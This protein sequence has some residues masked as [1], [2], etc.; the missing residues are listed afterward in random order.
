MIPFA[1]FARAAIFAALALA[2]L[3]ACAQEPGAPRQEAREEARRITVTGYGEAAAA[4]D[5]ARISAAVVAQGRT[6]QAAMAANAQAMSRVFD[7][8]REAGIA[9]RD[10]QTSSLSLSPQ[11]RRF[12]PGET[13]APEIIGYEARNQVSLRLREIAALGPALDRLVASGVN[14]FHGVSFDI[15]DRAP[16]L[17][18]ARRAA[19]ADARAKAELYAEAAGVALGRV[20]RISELGDG[21]PVYA[22]A[23]ALRESVAA[24][25]IAGGETVISAQVTLVYE[26]R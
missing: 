2:P 19:V 1:A 8:L 24:T 16:R 25:P 13:G 4:P 23:M 10:I 7:Q 20:I 6:A 15:A 11:Y 9:D 5:M 17:A 22:G 3:A 14:Q 21:G 12:G 26:L 18:A